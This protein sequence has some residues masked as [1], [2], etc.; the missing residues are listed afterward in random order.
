[1]CGGAFNSPQLLE[2]SGVGD[3]ARLGELGIPVIHE[4]P[5]VGAKIILSS[6]MRWR[7]QNT[8]TLNEKTK[9]LRAIGEGLKHWRKGALT[10]VTLPIGAVRTRPE[11][12]H[13]T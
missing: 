3:P 4:L 8:I 11:L 13:P 5:G 7:I 6:G 12:A 10:M 9:G 2:L 1:M